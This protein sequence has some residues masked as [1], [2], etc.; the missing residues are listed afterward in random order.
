M[1]INAEIQA[2]AVPIARLKPYGKNPRRGDVAA[3]KR[4][5]RENGQYR[6][7]VVR[8]QTMEVLAGNH[9]LEAARQLGW[10][11]LA[12]S[13]VDATAEQARRIVLVDN[14]TNDLAGY[15]EQALCELLAESASLD[16]TGY[17]EAALESLLAA[18]GA[19]ALP[20]QPE[21]PDLPAEPRTAPGDLYALGRH[22]LLCGDATDFAVYQRLLDG[23][24][25]QLLWTDP[26]Y[27][28]SYVGKTAAAL[29]IEN[30]GSE[31]L[32][33]L[34]RSSFAAADGALAAGAA[35]YVAHPAGA[36]SLTFANA[37]V[38]QGWRLRQTLVWVKD[39][40]VLGR[41]DY[42][43]RHEPILYGYKPGGGRRGR[44]ADGWYGDNAET[45]VIE[46]PRPKA[47]REH[48]TMKPPELI[49]VALRNSTRRADLG[50]EP[51]GFGFVSGL[52]FPAPGRCRSSTGPRARR[53]PSPPGG[54]PRRRS[55]GSAR[56]PLRSPRSRCPP[57]RR[58]ARRTAHRP[59]P[60]QPGTR[61]AARPARTAPACPA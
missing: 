11:E 27:G 21:L 16:G 55:R 14:R 29:T 61:P 54:G 58:R 31:T 22:R 45:T 35:L 12:V 36:Q 51:L 39:T 33:R 9:T 18:T 53:G 48:P 44:G 13:Y 15:D 2:L 52:G 19:E 49:A 34:L 3:I 26:P 7:L 25:A 17:D 60:G 32:E 30:D 4:S 42:H 37:F 38:G 43:Y 1:G 6:P 56:T 47:S 50:L 59:P 46:L 24:A 10:C 5:L 57:P 23:S 8:R 28:V 40:L 20:E 41:S